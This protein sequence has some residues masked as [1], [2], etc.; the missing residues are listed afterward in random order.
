[1]SLV[2]VY[3]AVQAKGP[4]LRLPPGVHGARPVLQRSVRGDLGAIVSPVARRTIHARSDDVR[5]HEAV[6]RAALEQRDPVLPLRFGTVFENAAEVEERLLDPG[7]DGLSGLLGE[8]R[9]LVEL[10]LRALYPDENELLRELVRSE[11][12]LARLR[13]ASRRG[14]YQAQLALGE[15]TLD[16]YRRR[17]EADTARLLDSLA[18]LVRD[19]RARESLPQRV[20]A[21][22]SFLVERARIGAFERAAAR[23]AH[24]GLRL[25]L[26]GPLPPYSF[27]TYQLDRGAVA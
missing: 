15:A 11:P 12:A 1:V 6:L 14:G 16:V 25:T 27:M 22:L 19:W 13:D 2:Y 20:A 10:E 4:P 8:F 21:Q 17:R 7:E 23:L 3:G 26:A 9:G 5:A 24:P 18:P